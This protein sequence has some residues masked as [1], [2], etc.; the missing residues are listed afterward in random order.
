ML[1]EQFK[2][3]TIKDEITLELHKSLKDIPHIPDIVEDFLQFKFL[4]YSL[5]KD[6]LLYDK[7]EGNAK[8]MDSSPSTRQKFDAFMFWLS[9]NDC[10]E[11]EKKAIVDSLN[12]DDF[13]VDELL[14]EVRM[15]G[16]YSVSKFTVKVLE[17][18]RKKDQLIRNQ[19]QEIVSNRS[20]LSGKDREIRELKSSLKDKENT[21]RQ[22]RWRR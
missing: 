3:N 22:L 21:I 12:F 13:T 10:G 11:D 15:S 5:V 6:I 2:L 14:T 9:E 19:E 8:V 7:G 1:A 4:P 16:L 20:L 18:L 17:V